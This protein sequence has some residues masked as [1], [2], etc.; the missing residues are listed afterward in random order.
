MAAKDQ[1]QAPTV[2]HDVLT[3]GGFAQ[4]RHGVGERGHL[5][6]R[7]RC[8]DAEHLPAGL[9]TVRPPMAAFSMD[10]SLES[11]PRSKSTSGGARGA[12]WR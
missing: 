11:G 12:S 6:E 10:T 5:S 1:A 3:L 4:H 7:E 9:M 8:L 2:R